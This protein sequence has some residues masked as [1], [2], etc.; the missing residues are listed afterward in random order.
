MSRIVFNIETVADP[1]LP[2]EMLPALPTL[3]EMSA[4]SNYKDQEKID[5]YKANALRLAF[6]A[7]E[8]EIA[9]FGLHALT[10]KIICL[11]YIVDDNTEGIVT[12]SGDDEKLIVET[13]NNLFPLVQRLIGYN[14]KSFDLHHLAVATI[15][16][17]FTPHISYADRMRRYG[18]DLHIDLYEVLSNFGNEKRGKLSDW[19]IRLGITPPFGKGSMVAEWYQKGDW[20]SIKHHCSD[21]VRC[22]YELLQKVGDLI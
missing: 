21:N 18:T 9:R 12:V 17:G 7:R 13:F 15:R 22:T 3:E 8:E 20:D 5:A 4:P 1:E 16:H 14:S 11:S 10:S 19:C 2:V 6:I